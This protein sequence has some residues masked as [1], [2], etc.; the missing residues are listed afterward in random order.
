MCE[1][2]HQVMLEM[3]ERLEI[4]LNNMEFGTDLAQDDIDVIRAALAN[5]KINAMNYSN[6]Y[7]TTLVM[8]S[9]ATM[10]LFQQLGVKNEFCWQ[11]LCLC[12]F[13]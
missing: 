2:L 1:E 12:S 6:Q 9:E 8:F 3:E 7:L 13:K 10:L 11:I 5:L 4:A